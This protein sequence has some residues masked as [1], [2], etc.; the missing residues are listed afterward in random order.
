DYIKKPIDDDE[1]IASLQTLIKSIEQEEREMAKLGSTSL[2]SFIIPLPRHVK[3]HL[4]DH[5][6]LFIEENFDKSIGLQEAANALKVSEG[7]LSRLFK[8]VTE[9]NFLGYLNA[10]RVNRSIE[11]LQNPRLNISAV[12]ALCGF[13]TPGY[14]TKLF[15]RFY[16]MTPS[17]FRDTLEV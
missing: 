9:I 1:L 10:Y 13:P 8:E 4:V 5:A 12:C 7:H 11:L 15:R 6:I 2:P 16:N 14:F 17:Q 3:N